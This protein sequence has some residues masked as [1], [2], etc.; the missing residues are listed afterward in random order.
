MLDLRYTYSS[1]LVASLLGLVGVGLYLDIYTLITTHPLLG[2]IRPLEESLLGAAARSY[3]TRPNSSEFGYVLALGYHDEMT[4]SI[5]NLM[6]MKCWAQ[7]VGLN[8]RVVEPFLQTSVL[9]MDLAHVPYKN[10][11]DEWG[12]ESTKLTDVYSKEKWD[13]LAFAPLISWN[14]FIRNAQRK[15]V[16]V[17]R[18]CNGKNAGKCMECNSQDFLRS[19]QQSIVLT[20]YGEF[21]T[22][23]DSCRTVNLKY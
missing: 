18:E 5:A 8:V 20:W 3:A 15:M 23:Y 10:T 7:S 21:V 9:G 6:S 17:D 22:L 2:T 14:Y 11:T 4:G 19:V 16:V 12:L 13:K 1:V